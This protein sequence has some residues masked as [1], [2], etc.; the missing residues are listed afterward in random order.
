MMDVRNA[1]QVSVPAAEY[2]GVTQEMRSRLWADEMEVAEAA[3]ARMVADNASRDLRSSETF[4]KLITSKSLQLRAHLLYARY[5]ESARG[6]RNV[7][8]V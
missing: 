3:R 1:R 8:S 6:K 4:L 5:T 7:V 2:V